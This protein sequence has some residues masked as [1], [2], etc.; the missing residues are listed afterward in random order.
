MN[1]SQS[2]TTDNNNAPLL[3]V[4]VVDDE[5]LSRRFIVS[6]LNWEAFG[7]EISSEAASGLEALTLLEE[8]TPDIIFTDI[9]MPYMDGLELSRLI[10]EKYPHIKIVILTAF[11]DFDYAQQSIQI[12]V[13]HFLLKPINHAELQ[14]T[15]LKLKEQIAEEKKKWFELD[16]LKKILK[17]NYSFLRERFLFE[18]LE[19]KIPSSAS[20]GQLSYYFPEGVPS[21]IQVTLLEAAS[22]RFL[23]TSEEERLLQDMKNLEFIK[24]YMEGTK[25]V[26]LFAD[27]NHHLVL[28]NYS[29]NLQVVTLCEQLKRS[30]YQTSGNEILFGIGNRY[31]SFYQAETS[32]QEALESLKYS[33]YMPDQPIVVYQNDIHVQ[34]SGWTS[35]PA[36]LEDIKFYIKAGLPDSVQKLLPSLYLTQDGNLL[37]L[38]HARIL[39]MTLL[40][41]AVNVA[42]DIGIPLNDLFSD[43]GSS[44]MQILLKPSSRD[45]CNE[46]GAFLTRLTTQIAECR[47]NKS[48][49]AL[50]DILQYIQANLTDASLSLGSVAETFH[51]ND[52]YLSRTFTKE[53]GFSFSKYLNRLRMERA[54]TLLSTTDLKAY[55]I[56][57]AVGIPDAYYFSNCFKKYTGKSVRDYRKGAT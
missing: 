19:D 57:E 33:R 54:I 1:I 27:N 22:P 3:K 44:F 11:K 45:L 18:L 39:S 49:S 55:Q 41:S 21:Y 9:K 48:K 30:I 56:A 25:D 20:A 23:E 4:M 47:T 38:E 35:P 53:L 29:P 5:E 32:W 51:M 26:E 36:E 40:S 7:L 15:I 24:K 2:N 46:T 43:P 31:D 50:W 14:S 52:S 28:L 37:S 10:T 12:G 17:D 8:Q 42:N 16:H 13:S 34:N 6:C